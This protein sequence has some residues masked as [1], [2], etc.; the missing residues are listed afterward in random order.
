MTCFLEIETEMVDFFPPNSSVQSNVANQENVKFKDPSSEI[1]LPQIQ[2]PIFNGKYEEWSSFRDLFTSMIVNNGS[3]SDVQ[4]LFYLK[5]QVSGEAEKLIKHISVTAVNFSSAWNILKDRYENKRVL[6]NV[7]LK[8]LLA[9]T[10]VTSDSAQAVKLL[11]DTTQECIA[12]LNNLEINTESWDPILVHI[13]AQKMSPECVQLWEQSLSSKTN[14]PTFQE[15]IS[16]LDS[17]FRTLEAVR[18]TSRPVGNTRDANRSI[19]TVP[20]PKSSFHV[21]KT[22]CGL[23]NGDHS[24]SR[25]PE[26]NGKSSAE[27]LQ[28]IKSKN[29]CFNCFSSSHPVRQCASKYSCRTCKRRHHS[30]LHDAVTRT[31]PP[32]DV[33]PRNASSSIPQETIEVSSHIAQSKQPTVDTVLLSTAIIKVSGPFGN[34]IVARAL[35]DQG[36]QVTFITEFLAQSLRLKKSPIRTQVIGI[37]NN[38]VKPISKATSIQIK[39]VDSEDVISEVNALVMKSLTSYAPSLSIKNPDWSHIRGLKLADPGFSNN[40]RIDLVLG[41]D[42]YPSI[43]LEGCLI[44]PKNAPMA[45]NTKFGWILSGPVGGGAQEASSSLQVSNL[46]S[47]HDVS[48]LHADMKKFWE[49]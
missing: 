27:T 11:L 13:I 17:R 16:F 29:L 21:A 7:H 38:Q 41:A 43:L 19:G 49:V 31:D 23:C 40:R 9:Q 42:L 32:S 10:K 22:T 46:V 26:L 39:S 6:V 15:L 12:A 44:G 47:F 14:V 30:M 4:K 36:S 35:L 34:E 5:S 25:C 28:V 48:D 3:L 1:K 45:Q 8:R 33:T 20:N 2:I 37:G 24:T 18:D